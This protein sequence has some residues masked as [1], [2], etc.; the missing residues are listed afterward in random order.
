M[1]HLFVE[2]KPSLFS[3][4]SEEMWIIWG[5]F[6]VIS[7]PLY[8]YKFHSAQDVDLSCVNIWELLSKLNSY[9]ERVL[10][11]SKYSSYT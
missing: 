8:G 2:S 6:G 5:S 4:K 1:F 7:G 11:R 9:R 3:V 10:S